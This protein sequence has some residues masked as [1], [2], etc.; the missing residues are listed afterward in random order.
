[1]LSSICKSALFNQPLHSLPDLEYIIPEAVKQTVFPLVYTALSGEHDLSAHQSQYFGIISKNA[2]VFEEHKL[3]HKLLSDN[4]IPYVF[5]KGCASARYYPDPLLRT[6]GDVDLLISPEDTEKVDSLLISA[7][8]KKYSDSDNYSTHI[9]YKSKN[10]VV[11]ELHRQINGI[12]QNSIGEKITAYFSDIFEKAVLVNSEYLCPCDFHHGLILLLHSSTHLLKEGIGLRHLCDWAIFIAKF[13]DQEFINLFEKPLKE[14]G[15][16]KFAVILSATS[17][18]YL[19]CPPKSWCKNCDQQIIDK[20]IEDIFLGG[21]FGKKDVSRYQQIKYISHRS[22][23]TIDNSSAIRNSLC[24][25]SLKAKSE[26]NFVKKH[27]FLLP[28]GWIAVISKYLY[29]VISEKRK[30]DSKRVITDAA[31]RKNLYSQFELYK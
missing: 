6:M 29:L 7:G 18:K 4:D 13:N 25:I 20:L 14:I 24:N 19:G 3:L 9:G 12:P 28:I 22:N 5:L 16:W 2:K 1:M 21:N 17:V 15:L 11:C 27:S 8:Y 31:K 30:L 10:G 23:K 26:Y